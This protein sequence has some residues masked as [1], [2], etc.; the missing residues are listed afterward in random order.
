MMKQNNINNDFT[1]SMDLRVKPEDD[2]RVESGR[3]MVEMLGTLAIIGVLSVGSIAGYR[4]A[5]D[6]H[7]SNELL[8]GA[9]ER[10]VL[11]TAQITVGRTPSLAEFEG[12]E[13]SGGTFGDAEELEDGNGFIIPVSGVKGAVCENL[14]KATEGT[15][16]TIAN[17]DESLSEATCDDENLNNLVFVYETGIGGGETIDPACA[18]VECPVAGTACV[19]GSCLCP[20]GMLPCKG[21]CCGEGEICSAPGT[22]DSGTVGECVTPTGECVTNADCDPREFCRFEST[23]SASNAGTTCPVPANGVCT[24]LTDSYAKK[25]VENTEEPLYGVTYS[26]AKMNWWSASNWCQANGSSL[27][28]LATL[29]TLSGGNSNDAR[30]TA[31]QGG[32]G[33][34]SGYVWLEDAYSSTSCNARYVPLLDGTVYLTYSRSNYNFSALCR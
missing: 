16:I 9:S 21:A 13:V 15:N 5:M 30:K 10:A 12:Q 1:C 2:R 4:Y 24:P 27:M 7:R 6:K 19:N 20:D 31:L 8:S 32:L 26:D 23:T 3:S 18:D 22:G 33:K 29:N 17:D 34:T 11:V 14:I 28:S 25:V